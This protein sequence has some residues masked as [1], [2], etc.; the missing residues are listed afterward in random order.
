MWLQGDDD[1]DDDDGDD[2]DEDDAG[3]DEGCF[4]FCEACEALSHRTTICTAA[5]VQLFYTTVLQ[6]P[7]GL[8]Q[9]GLTPDPRGAGRT[10]PSTSCNTRRGREG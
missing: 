6:R 8:I 9:P 7:K 10:H 2:D 3:D 1:D 5:S 4:S